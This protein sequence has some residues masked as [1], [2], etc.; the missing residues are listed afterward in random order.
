MAKSICEF[1]A[2]RVPAYKL[3]TAPVLS[4]FAHP[5]HGGR[6]AKSVHWAAEG[7]A[8]ENSCENKRYFASKRDTVGTLLLVEPPA[9]RRPNSGRRS[10]VGR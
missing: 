3:R 10:G 2:P 1:L 4:M 8:H 7:A 5:L 6:P 9:G